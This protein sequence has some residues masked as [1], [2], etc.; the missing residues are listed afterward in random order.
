MSRNGGGGGGGGPLRLLLMDEGGGVGGHPTPS[1]HSLGGDTMTLLHDEQGTPSP[2]HLLDHQ[3]GVTPQNQMLQRPLTLPPKSQMVKRRLN[4]DQDEDESPFKAPKSVK[5]MRVNPP[6]TPAKEKG[7]R[8]DTSLG[9]LTKKFVNLLK[10]SPQGVVDLNIASETLD[11]QKRRIYD[12]T[13]VLEGIGIL[14]KKSKNNIQW[15]GGRMPTSQSSQ[16]QADINHL[17]G[18]EQAIDMLI[19]DAESDLQQLTAERRFSYVTYQDIRHIPAYQDRTVM[20]VKAP[21]ESHLEVPKPTR[22]NFLQMFMRSKTGPIEVF[23][24]P[25]PDDV[26]AGPTPVRKPA[27]HQ[28]PHQQHAASAVSH[29][30]GNPS[31]SSSSS[32]PS[33]SQ[34]SSPLVQCSNEIKEEPPDPTTG[35]L[36]YATTSS[37]SSSRAPLTSLHNDVM[38]SANTS[39]GGGAT[40]SFGSARYH[41]AAGTG[42]NVGHSS[43]IQSTA[44]VGAGGSSSSG[45]NSQSSSTAATSGGSGESSLDSH[46]SQFSHIEPFLPLEPPLTSADYSFCLAPD[47]GLSDLFSDYC[48]H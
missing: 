33:S 38:I 25:E 37:S 9:L 31:S 27:H 47:E 42:S 23:L 39:S 7:T 11:V 24:C 30:Q 2:F 12:I 20:L 35:P 34:S 18:K 44:S 6:T 14:E 19:A 41:S 28:T 40:S 21:P 15:K 32:H 45:H 16:L 4:L 46:V 5:K 48:S 8:Y 36:P 17:A 13:N 43:V 10:C 3:Y 29:R 22:P 26:A 1:P